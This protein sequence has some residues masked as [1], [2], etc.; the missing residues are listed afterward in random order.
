[1]LPPAVTCPVHTLPVGD[2]VA[3]PAMVTARCR[4]ETD[5]FLLL[6]AAR[7]MIANNE[8]NR[9]TTACANAPGRRNQRCA[10][11]LQISVRIS[12]GHEHAGYFTSNNGSRYKIK[13]G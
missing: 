3:W 2:T 12:K 8:Q 4:S 9:Y 10:T 13:H 11:R 7:M 1:M 5:Y 6:A